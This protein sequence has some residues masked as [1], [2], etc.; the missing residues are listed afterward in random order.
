VFRPTDNSTTFL[1]PLTEVLTAKNL[2]TCH[3][4]ARFIGRGICFFATSA[5]QIPYWNDEEYQIGF[6]RD[7]LPGVT[8]EITLARSP[9]KCDETPISLED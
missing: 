3:S 4:D 2:K 6:F 8:S 7:N 1:L 5:R 9:W